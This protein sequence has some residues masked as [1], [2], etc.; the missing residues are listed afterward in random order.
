MD[1]QKL[2]ITEGFDLKKFLLI[3]VIVLGFAVESQACHLFRGRSK[4]AK[5][6]TASGS[7][8]TQQTQ[9]SPVRAAMIQQCNGGTC[10]LR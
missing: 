9:A 5:C 1:I 3:A 4:A 2:P 8:C 6:S 7:A 10:P